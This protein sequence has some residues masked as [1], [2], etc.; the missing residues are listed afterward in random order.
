MPSIETPTN[1]RFDFLEEQPSPDSAFKLDPAP[2]G[3]AFDQLQEESEKSYN[4]EKEK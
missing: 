3:Y 2:M 4:V 1:V